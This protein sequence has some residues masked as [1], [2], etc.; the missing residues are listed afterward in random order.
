MEPGTNY[1]AAI[2]VAELGQEEYNRRLEKQNNL[3][4]VSLLSAAVDVKFSIHI[5]IGICTT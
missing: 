4:K 5:Y 3:F 1:S 2:A